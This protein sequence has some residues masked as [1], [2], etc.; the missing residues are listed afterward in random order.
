MI[1]CI[2]IKMKEIRL[3]EVWIADKYLHSNDFLDFIKGLLMGWL[4]FKLDFA[5]C[6]AS[7]WV[8]GRSSLMRNHMS[9]LW[10]TI[11]MKWHRWL[12]FSYLGRLNIKDCLNL[13]MYRLNTLSGDPIFQVFY[14]LCKELRFGDIHSHTRISMVES[15]ARTISNLSRWSLKLLFVSINNS[16]R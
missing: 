16:S 12:F 8:L 15:L 13:V 5:W 2:S 1:W 11:P 10:L 6:E 14:L 4:P 9:R 7:Q 3:I